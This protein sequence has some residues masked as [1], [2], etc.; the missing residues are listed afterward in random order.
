M[1]VQLY[2]PLFGEFCCYLSILHLLISL[3]LLFIIVAY[4]KS[5]VCLQQTSVAGITIAVDTNL[6]S[7]GH[8]TW[9]FVHTCHVLPQKY[10]WANFQRLITVVADRKST[11]WHVY[12]PR[13]LDIWPWSWLSEG[14]KAF[15]CF[16]E[17]HTVAEAN[18]KTTFLKKV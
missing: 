3:L 10:L 4:W 1:A 9:N 5:S 6:L 14:S 18:L 7:C 13:K 8:L 17:I 12:Y 11:L 2:S 15:F 16:W